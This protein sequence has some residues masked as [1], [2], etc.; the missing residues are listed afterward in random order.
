MGVAGF[1]LWQGGALRAIGAGMLPMAFVILFGLVGLASLIS[2]LFPNDERLE[3]WTLCRPMM[4]RAAVIAYG[5]VVRPLGL[6]VAG[7]LAIIITAAASPET[8]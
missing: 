2:G 5:I 3:R 7:S 4:I 6:A 8:R 1:A